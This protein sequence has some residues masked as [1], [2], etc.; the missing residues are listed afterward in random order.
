MKPLLV[1]KLGRVLDEFLETVTEN[2]D[3]SAP[4]TAEFALTKERLAGLLSGFYRAPFTVQR[5]LEL[6]LEP[7]KHY[8][9][10]DKYSRGLEKVRL[11]IV[12]RTIF[13][14]YIE[15]IL[16]LTRFR[17]SKSM[18]GKSRPV[19]F[20]NFNTSRYNYFLI[21]IP[22]LGVPKLKINAH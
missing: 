19:A 4:S 18:Y 6:L 20:T 7:N 22:L 12:N 16:R 17:S 13:G 11:L 10:F 2:G 5:L 3:V 9:K 21:S 15:Q 14:C 1:Y 8:K